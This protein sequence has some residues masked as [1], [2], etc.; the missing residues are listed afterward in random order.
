[1]HITETVKIKKVEK[2]TFYNAEAL[3][4]DMFVYKHNRLSSLLLASA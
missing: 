1:M 2:L 4:I 3:F